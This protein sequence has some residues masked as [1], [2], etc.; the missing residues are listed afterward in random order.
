MRHAL[1]T[2][3][4]KGLGKKVTEM[5]LHKGYAV[6]AN[7]RSD[8]RAAHALLDQFSTH[9]DHLQTVQGDVS[10]KEDCDRIVR[11]A[12]KT[13]D[14]VDC[15][16]HNAGPYVFEHKRLADYSDEEWAA[17]VNGN[18]SSAFYLTRALIPTMRKQQFGRIVTYGF[19]NSSTAPGWPYRSAHAAAK[20]GLTS[21][22]KTIALEEAENGITANM[23]CPGT[24][25]GDMKESSIEASRKE[26]DDGTPI[27]RSGT[28][29]DIA[30]MVAFLCEDNSD[31]ITG[32]VVDVSGGLD[33]IH[34]SLQNVHTNV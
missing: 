22:T 9:A 5:M 20:V 19:Q 24:I 28:G 27:G 6:T 29:E 23:V 15:L 18:L 31:M 1:V 8:E 32:A 12:L 4:T 26:G 21:L 30:R 11:Q 17:M 16:I 14:R 7:F 13:F 3:G 10:N 2:A 25:V 34:Q 33:V